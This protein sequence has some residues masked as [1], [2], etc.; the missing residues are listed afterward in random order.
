VTDA[1]RKVLEDIF[2]RHAAGDW[3]MIVQIDLNAQEHPQVPRFNYNFQ[4][5]TASNAPVASLIIE[6]AGAG[7]QTEPFSRE[8]S[9]EFDFTSTEDHIVMS[10]S[11]GPERKKNHHGVR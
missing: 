2:A 6:E 4:P 11:S 8:S 9:P 3:S 10:I 1:N 7:A 5:P